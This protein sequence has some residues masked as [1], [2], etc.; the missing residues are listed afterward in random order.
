MDP[1]RLTEFGRREAMSHQDN[2]TNVTDINAHA[3]EIQVLE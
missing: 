2:V 1:K 3:R